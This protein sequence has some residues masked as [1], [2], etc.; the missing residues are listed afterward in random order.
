ML[1]LFVSSVQS[2]FAEERRAIKD[3][4]RQDPLLSRHFKTF[5]FEDV[6]AQT[7]G[8]REIFLDEVDRCT[9]YVGL[10]GT[11][12]GFEDSEGISPTER[13]FERAVECR[14]ERLIFIKMGSERNRHSKMSALVAKAEAQLT[15]S[16]FA[17]VPTLLARLQHGLVEILARAGAI[18]S[19]RFERHLTRLTADDADGLV[20][21]EFARRA[22]E[23]LTFSAPEQITKS[24][25]LT[26]LGLLRDGRLTRAGA[27]LFTSEP[28]RHIEGA[29]VTCQ[30]FAGTEPVRPAPALQPFE[31]PLF[32]QIEGAVNFVLAGLNRPIGVR[33]HSIT[34]VHH[35]ELPEAAVREA[36]I[37]AVAHRDYASSGAVQVRLF[38][39][40]LDI[41]NPG[42][43]PHELTPEAL[44]GVHDSYPR[45]SDVMDV[46][47]RMR[48]G[49][50]TGY[51]T[52]EMTRLCREAG[53]PEPE[54]RQDGGAFIV[55]FWR[56][57]LN[58]P[59]LVEIGL[60]KRQ[61]A[62][63]VGAKAER[64]LTTQQYMTLTGAARATAKRDL[65][66]LVGLGLLTAEGA[67]RGASYPFARNRPNFGSNG[68]SADPGGNGSKMAQTAPTP[69]ARR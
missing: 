60:H 26:R 37:N 6:P 66:D 17:D 30:R 27:I 54:F 39:D 11:L 53:L 40:R 34:A 4:V 41:S 55:R 59:F 9:V 1:T 43:L 7:R 68:S 48:Y 45:N 5:I 52:T 36:I 42:A 62:G 8:P 63:L 31:G 65:D 67:G 3:H 15:R 16:I 46:L 35:Y 12:Y 49:E 69:K 51:G 29:R 25:V 20:V 22:R 19:E 33:D 61:I 56:D 24:D 64:R 57:W 13:E 50:R 10:F 23:N 58:E 21:E 47:R 44:K 14:K 2:E 38:S 32:S 18:D 28:A